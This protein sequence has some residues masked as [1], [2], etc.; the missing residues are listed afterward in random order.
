ML[1][2]AANYTANLSDRAQPEKDEWY[3]EEFYDGHL[4]TMHPSS[5][6]GEFPYAPAMHDDTIHLR[7]QLRHLFS[8]LTLGV[9]DDD[10]VEEAKIHRRTLGVLE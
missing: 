10:F 3:F 8:F 4:M 1:V 5:R 9:L 6:F 2:C 7:S